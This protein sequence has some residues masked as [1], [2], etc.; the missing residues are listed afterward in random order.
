MVASKHAY[1]P[2]RYLVL[3][4]V[5][6]LGNAFSEAREIGFNRDVR[7][8]LS[9]NCFECHGPDEKSR[10]AG[11]RLDTFE[12]ATADNDGVR[13]IVPGDPASSEILR[14]LTTSDPSDRMPPPESKKT[15]SE[16]EVEIL[17]Q[18]IEQGANYQRHWSFIP[19][20]RPRLPSVSSMDRIGNP[21]DRFVLSRLEDEGLSFSAQASPHTLVRRLYL[22]LIGLP[23]S[24]EVADAFAKDPSPEAYRRLVDELLTSPAYGERWARRWLDLARYSDTNGSE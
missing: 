18:W 1:L 6:L 5:F 22:D 16:A 4:L 13:A 17:R 24:P 3:S 2:M 23:P 7:S 9:A 12:G 20:S 8:I 11:L 21:I 14:R 10:E 15:V 19:P